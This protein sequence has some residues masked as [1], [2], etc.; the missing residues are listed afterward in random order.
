MNY[1]AGLQNLTQ[2]APPRVVTLGAFDG[3]HRGHRALLQVAFC[4]AQ[5]LE[6]ETTV[7]TF[8]PT[9]AEVFHRQGRSNL[10][11]TLPP[12][13]RELL[14]ALGLDTLV[15]AQFDSRLRQMEPEQFA[16]EILVERLGTT[17]V[18]ASETHTFGRQGSGDLATLSR[19]GRQMGFEVQIL[20]LLSSKRNPLSSTRIR[21]LLWGGQVAE[22]N[23]LLGRAYTCTGRVT[24]GA[25]RGRELG[26]ATANLSVPMP[27]LV[28]GAGVYAGWAS[29][30]ATPEQHSPAGETG[31]PAALCVGG[32]PTF[33][34]EEDDRLIEAHLLDLEADLQGQTLTVAF[35]QWLR[36]SRR[37]AT[38]DQ[39]KDQV[40]RDLQ[41][42]RALELPM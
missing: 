3:V 27:K 42:V 24:A 33:E 38:A 31:W 4:V 10:R 25:G 41:Q 12:E 20:P 32:S 11:L 36:P 7:L 1:V 30:A 40:H 13:R 22:A 35:A 37:F 5:E 19:L 2:P 14:E 29:L 21:E 16:Q 6:A 28:P 9:P 34:G 18:I 8:E 15:V 17:A 39:L 26:F 23:H